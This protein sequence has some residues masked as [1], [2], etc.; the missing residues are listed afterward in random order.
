MEEEEEEK[1]SPDHVS[2]RAKGHKGTKGASQSP[3]KGHFICG[4]KK[5]YKVLKCYANHI[6]D[7]H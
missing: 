3:K 4:C 7:V 1:K 5:E 6:R 2:G